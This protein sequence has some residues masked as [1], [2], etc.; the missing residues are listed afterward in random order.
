MGQTVHAQATADSSYVRAV[1]AALQ[2]V[3]MRQKSPWLWPDCLF[4]VSPLGREYQRC[5]AILHGFT[6]KVIR[7]RRR[8]QASTANKKTGASFTNDTEEEGTKKLA[9]LDLLLA[10]DSDALSDGDIAE[11]IDTFMFEGHDTTAANLAFT[12]YLLAMHPEVQDRCWE[13]QAELFPLDD[14]NRRPTMKDLGRMK[15]LEACI[16]E[17]LR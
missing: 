6:A 7:Q 9:L 2:I 11:E 8:R 5:L 1:Y 13:E 4:K 16:K 12:L 15:Y 14:K 17:S 3:H 10:A